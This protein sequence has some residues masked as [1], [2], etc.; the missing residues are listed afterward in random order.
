MRGP[1][2]VFGASLLVAGAAVVYAHYAQV[3]DQR[4][5]HEGVERDKE[6]L[7]MKR[8]LREQGAASSG[9]DQSR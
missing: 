4:Q 3:R 6:R 8:A 1:Q 7:R 9:S 5:M 2:A